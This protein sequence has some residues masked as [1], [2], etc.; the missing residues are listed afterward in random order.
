MS[1]SLENAFSF[2]RFPAREP[3]WFIRGTHKE[4]NKTKKGPLA[5]ARSRLCAGKIQIDKLP[6]LQLLCLDSFSSGLS[7]A[8][9]QLTYQRYN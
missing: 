1:G 8:L 2:F 3:E 9:V 4:K 6:K 7:I 5:G